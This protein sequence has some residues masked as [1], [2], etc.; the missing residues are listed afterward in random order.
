V[1]SPTFDA[2][3]P[4]V[5]ASTVSLRPEP[6]GALAYDFKT[7]RLSFLKTTTLVRVVES[8][9]TLPSASE[10]MRVAGVSC[11]EAESY[12][13]AL[14]RLAATGMIQRRVAA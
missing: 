3:S 6:F 13:R 11:G 1:A 7:R 10:A 4:W 2:E 5:L 9:E 8:L 14:A 12:M